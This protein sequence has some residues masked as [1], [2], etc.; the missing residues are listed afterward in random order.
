MTL[1][2]LRALLAAGTIT[3][4]QA[5]A[6]LAELTTRA[7]A[8]LAEAQAE[9]TTAER[10]AVVETEHAQMLRE[11]AGVRTKIT[12]A[13]AEA[14][15]RAAVTVPP[16]APEAIGEAVR[17]GIVGERQRV[18]NLRSLGAQFQ[19]PADF[20]ERHISLGTDETAY[21]AAILEALAQRSAQTPLF[22]HAE[23]I[24]DEVD[25]RRLGMR[26]AIV[27]RMRRA[28][29]ERNIQVPAHAQNWAER[30]LSEIAAEC[31][32]WRGGLRTQR[33][34]TDMFQR[35][36][37]S[38][39]DF[40]GIFTDALNVSLLARYQV[41]TPTYRRWAAPYNAADFR[42]Q[43]VIRAGDFPTLQPID[44]TGEVKNG[45]FGESAEQF[46]V[47]PYGV[48]LPISRQMII[49]DRLGAIA[50]VL[51][52][53]G[54]RVSDWENGIAYGVL[55]AGSGVGPTLLTDN[56]VVFH[57]SHAN[58]ASMGTVIDIANVGAGRAA[59]MKQTTIDNI[60]ANFVPMTILCGPDKLTQAEQ[61]LTSITP[62][63][64]ASAVP[65]SMRRLIPYGDAY[66]SGNA[67][68]LFADPNTAP[69]F[70]Y[71]YLDGFEGP[72]LSNE[73]VF[74]MQGMKFKLE[75]DFGVA[76]I[77]YRGAYRNPG[78]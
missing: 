72:R 73:E 19:Q 5:R 37:N 16:P 69:C 54:D 71:G 48:I 2:Q 43:H 67:W 30:E 1:E 29:G 53:A 70:L 28:N 32:N 26:D 77:D 3:L 10:A 8:L 27:A 40:P 65:E 60:K 22:P 39:S 38:T 7:A 78:A 62:A 74:D 44:Q 52:S 24:R 34:V 66:I 13:E 56:V 35:A 59:M 9:S 42:A 23:I 57:S 45:T 4:E 31:I 6:L 33:Q 17:A 64:I 51:N 11:I 18:S 21:R 50:Q 61:L 58:L 47:N 41:A 46:K 15:T 20:I 36:F 68:Y 25:T 49:N 76:A 63:L 12:A 75:H 14:A 55:L